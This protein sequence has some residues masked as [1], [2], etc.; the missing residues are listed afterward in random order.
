MS[1]SAT[2]LLGMCSAGRPSS[3]A[4]P[5]MISRC[6][7]PS[8]C[9]GRLRRRKISLVWRG[10]ARR[11]ETPHRT[12]RPASGLQAR[13]ARYGRPG[14][15]VGV[16]AGQWLFSYSGGRLSQPRVTIIGAGRMGQG[17]G[18]A[19]KRRGYRVLLLNR[20]PR[21][22]VP[23]LILHQGRL[24]EATAGAEL[25]L[26]ATPDDAIEEVAAEL[27]ARGDISHDQ[28]IL[29]LSGLLDRRALQPLDPPR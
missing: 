16:G 7:P 14:L 17:L 15:C 8:G 27:A 26:I 4:V 19:L 29:H 23:P 6:R 3:A 18:L 11:W 5:P 25:I 22:G 21:D 28:V 13:S 1:S 24:S 20:S 10:P 2:R 9:F 12:S